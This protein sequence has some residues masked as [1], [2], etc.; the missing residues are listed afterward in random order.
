MPLAGT[1]RAGS[2]PGLAPDGPGIDHDRHG[3]AGAI[4]ATLEHAV[5]LHAPLGPQVGAIPIR[6]SPDSGP[7]RERAG[8]A[9][10]GAQVV[11]GW[12][13]SG[14]GAQSEAEDEQDETDE[15]VET[16]AVSVAAVTQEVEMPSVDVYGL[17]D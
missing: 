4:H 2:A 12:A 9:D 7:A 16:H 17:T 6:I 1:I 13:L 8:S 15:G 14:G 10:A 3:A 11:A 5:G